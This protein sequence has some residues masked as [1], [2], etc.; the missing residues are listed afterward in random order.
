MATKKKAA[1]A[2]KPVAKPNPYRDRSLPRP[3]LEETSITDCRPRIWKENGN[4]TGPQDVVAIGLFERGIPIE[5]ISMGTGLRVDYL[6]HLLGL[7]DKLTATEI[8]ELNAW[9]D[10]EHNI[11]PTTGW[12]G[13]F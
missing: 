12:G 13:G 11:S 4:A 7:K 8:R 1:K 5:E 9:Y 2:N 10:R 6:I 3:G